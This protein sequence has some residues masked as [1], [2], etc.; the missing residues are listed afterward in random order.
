[1][2]CVRCSLFIFAHD[3]QQVPLA[4]LDASQNVTFN[5][6]TIE[7]MGDSTSCSIDNL[8]LV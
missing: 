6:I 8:K 4:A 3:F 2:W 1:M 7:N 5:R